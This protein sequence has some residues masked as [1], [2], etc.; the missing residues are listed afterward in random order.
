[1]TFYFVWCGKFKDFVNYSVRLRTVPQKLNVLYPNCRRK[2]TDWK[3]EN[4][5]MEWYFCLQLVCLQWY[6]G[7]CMNPFLCRHKYYSSI[8]WV[9]PMNT[10]FKQKK[11]FYNHNFL[12]KIVPAPLNVFASSI[13]DLIFVCIYIY[14]YTYIWLF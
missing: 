11:H 5:S 12:S 9:F 8:K 2:L 14:T 6:R 1:M 10:N 4:T 7:M 13:I 3:V